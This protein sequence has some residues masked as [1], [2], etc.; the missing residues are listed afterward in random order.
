MARPPKPVVRAL[1]LC[2]TPLS[3][4]R[5]LSK[6]LPPTL[7]PITGGPALRFTLRALEVAR[8]DEAV[9]A[10]GEGDDRVERQLGDTFGEL[11]LRYEYYAEQPGSW[12]AAA[13]LVAS[14]EG[15]DALVIVD[16]ASLCRWPLKKLIKRH[17]KSG[18]A[19]TLLLSRHARPED[20]GGGMIVDR[21]G[22]ILA[23][24]PGGLEVDESSKLR[25]LVFT[26]AQVIDPRLLHDDPPTGD[27]LRD[28]YEPLLLADGHLGFVTTRRHWHHVSTPWRYLE[29]A[30]NWGRGRW[31][32]R[33]FRSNWMAR[34][35]RRS[36]GV[37]A[38]LSVIEKGAEVGA[39]TRLERAALLTGVTV[40]ERCR[41][42]RSIIAP[43]VK[44]PP[45]TR[46]S[47]RLIT[48][49]TAGRDPGAND[50]VVGD[51]VYT[52]IDRGER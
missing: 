42:S 14:L 30:R 47:G 45:Q 41:V 16:G 40:G 5:P 51:L 7:L 17:L 35:S 23:L 28:L 18:A 25:E 48:P 19:A 24:R 10:L 13:P 26:G 38:R 9:L 32:L 36:R 39:G 44:L 6:T 3:R 12:G 52:P 15:T 4:L 27:L 33:L 43:G 2:Q 31:P 1:V 29:A 22:R 8:V 50:S 20:H 37:R 49:L 11:P 21:D 46:V 34:E